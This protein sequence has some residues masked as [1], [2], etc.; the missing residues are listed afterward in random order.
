M[1]SKPGT[2]SLMMGKAESKSNLFCSS[3]HVRRQLIVPKY[4]CESSY[5]GQQL[6][7]VLHALCWRECKGEAQYS[8]LVFWP[9]TLLRS[10]MQ[11]PEVLAMSS[12]SCAAKHLQT[13]VLLLRQLWLSH[14][15]AFLGARH[16]SQG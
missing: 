6:G 2:E 15:S 5:C 13:S 8:S 4:V 7:Q 9:K 10:E 11:K 14:A 12:K 3:A 16:S 1:Y